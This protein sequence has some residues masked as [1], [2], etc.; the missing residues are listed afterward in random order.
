MTFR[1]TKSSGSTGLVHP[2]S[3]LRGSQEADVDNQVIIQKSGRIHDLESGAKGGA[4]WQ[5]LS[6]VPDKALGTMC[7]HTHTH[8]HTHSLS[9]LLGGEYS[10]L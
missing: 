9:S 8:S 5:S 2:S 3:Q 4:Q 10:R 7:E 1:R 6:D